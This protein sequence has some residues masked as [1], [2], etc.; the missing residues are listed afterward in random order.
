MVGVISSG[1]TGLGFVLPN[2]RVWT[3]AVRVSPLINWIT[4]T[5]KQGSPMDRP[6]GGV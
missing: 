3:L 4:N 2:E 5:T 1:N 6:L